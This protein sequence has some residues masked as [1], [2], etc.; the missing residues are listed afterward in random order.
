MII[1]NLYVLIDKENDEHYGICKDYETALNVARRYEECS[2]E[3]GKTISISIY[4]IGD[5]WHF[6]FDAYYR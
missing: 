1:K 5:N 4:E 6:G 2:K 3:K